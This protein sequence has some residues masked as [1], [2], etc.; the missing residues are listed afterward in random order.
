VGERQ[1]LSRG[2]CGMVF[3]RRMG[4]GRDKRQP[5]SVWCC[6]PRPWASGL[7][8]RPFIKGGWQPGEAKALEIFGDALVLAVGWGK[9]S[10]AEKPERD[11]GPGN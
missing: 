3:N 6:A 7:R 2:F 10:P 11:R 1:F 4:K 9:A 5:Y 8:R